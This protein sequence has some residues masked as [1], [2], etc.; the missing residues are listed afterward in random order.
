MYLNLQRLDVFRNI[1]RGTH[2]DVFDLQTE[3]V[4]ADRG[5]SAVIMNNGRTQHGLKGR[6]RLRR[7]EIQ[8]AIRSYSELHANVPFALTHYATN[9]SLVIMGN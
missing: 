5:H 6:P 2:F 8:T 1:R 9:V 7:S 4:H 3:N